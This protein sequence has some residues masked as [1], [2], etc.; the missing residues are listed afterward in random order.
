MLYFTPLLSFLMGSHVGHVAM[1]FH[2][3]ASGYLF[4]WIIMGIDP[5]PKPLPYSARFALVL[6]ALGV[7]GFF[8]VIVMMSSQ[9]LA[10]EWYSIVRPDWVTDPVAD[11]VFGGQVA[12]GISEIPMLFMV[13]VLTWHWM[14]RDERDARR[15]DRQAARDG[16]AQLHAYNAY[17]DRINTRSKQ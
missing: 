14:Q 3:I 17:L 15:H 8:A 13:I 10:P 4:A 5:V 9:P 1:Q 6:L 11:T 12:W 7:H 2:F 16:D